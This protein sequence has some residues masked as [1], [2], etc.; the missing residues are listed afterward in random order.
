MHVFLII[1]EVVGRVL[2]IIIN[3][4]NIMNSPKK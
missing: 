4:L 3:H 1:S 2:A